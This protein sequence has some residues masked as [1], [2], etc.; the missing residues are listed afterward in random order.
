MCTLKK[1]WYLNNNKKQLR[2]K[3]CKYC[4]KDMYFKTFLISQQ[5]NKQQQQ[6]QNTIKTKIK[7]WKRHANLE[8]AKG[9]EGTQG[10]CAEKQAVKTLL[11]TAITP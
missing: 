6:Q 1:N 10:V 2:L 4:W 7:I 3:K 8:R 5:T 11:I 9:E